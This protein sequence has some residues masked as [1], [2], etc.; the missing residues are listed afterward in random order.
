MSRFL[1]STGHVVRST[2]NGQFSKFSGGFTFVYILKKYSNAI[3]VSKIMAVAEVV[4]VRWVSDLLVV[5]GAGISQAQ[6]AKKR[7]C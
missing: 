6:Q 2:T 3:N 4:C 1:K 5:N 7:S